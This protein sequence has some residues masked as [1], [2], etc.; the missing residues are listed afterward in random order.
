MYNYRFLFFLTCLL[1][2][3]TGYSQNVGIGTNNPTEKLEVNGNIKS[4]GVILNNGGSPYDFLTKSNN[5]GEVGYKKGHGAV[6]LNYIICIS[7]VFPMA[8]GTPAT[9]PMLGE[10]KL[11]AG[12]V[13]PAGW[14]FCNGQ[15]M[16]IASNTA[17]FS[18]LGISYGGNGS[19]V[20]ALPD[21]RGAA[22]VSSGTATIG[23]Q[24]NLGQR[25]N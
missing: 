17:L 3:I 22:A 19:T 24:W 4:T 11:F 2:A 23:Y 9:T 21:L 13:A 14:A 10:V 18:I 12:S 16:T 15:L 5:E 6:A 25:S 1:M 8:T 7:G 20:F